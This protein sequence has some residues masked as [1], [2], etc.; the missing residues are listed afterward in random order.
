MSYN[1][2]A[3]PTIWQTNGGATLGVSIARSDFLRDKPTLVLQQLMNRPWSAK[4]QRAAEDDTGRDKDTAQ[5]SVLQ[6][7]A[8]HQAC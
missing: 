1:Q 7:R 2:P 5:L 6:R 8:L 3:V 4:W